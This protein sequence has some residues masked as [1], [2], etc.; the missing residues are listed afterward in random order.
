[1]RS[2]LRTKSD[3]TRKAVARSTVNIYMRTLSLG[4]FLLNSISESK[5][6]KVI[7]AVNTKFSGQTYRIKV[8]DKYSVKIKVKKI[9]FL[10]PPLKEALVFE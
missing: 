8:R 4:I 1:M 7:V 5:P 9:L 2:V 6:R 3:E 10:S